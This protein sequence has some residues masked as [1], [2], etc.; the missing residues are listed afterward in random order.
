MFLENIV[1]RST[2]LGKTSLRA[3]I[4]RTSSKVSPSGMNLFDSDCMAD[5]VIIGK[6]K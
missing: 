5:V 3:G 6:D 2:S 4:R 1:E